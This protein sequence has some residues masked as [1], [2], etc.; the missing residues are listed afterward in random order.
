[1]S[2]IN[3]ILE[4]A[5]RTYS[6]DMKTVLIWLNT[7]TPHQR[8]TNLLVTSTHVTDLDEHVGNRSTV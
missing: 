1:M 6:S 3:K 8:V 5:S 7:R 2:K 4:N